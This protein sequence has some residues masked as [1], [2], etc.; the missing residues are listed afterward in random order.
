MK[1][2]LAWLLL[3][4]CLAVDAQ[5]FKW[6]DAQGK[7]HYG[8]QPPMDVKAQEMKITRIPPEAPSPDVEVAPVAIDHYPVRGLSVDAIG[9]AMQRAAPKGEDGDPVWAQASWSL[10]YRF[11]FDDSKGCRIDTLSVLVSTRL[12]MPE[13]LDREKAADELQ[14]KW[15]AFYR[16]L[17]AHEEGHRDNGIRAANDLARKIRKLGSARD[18]ATLD[19]DVRELGGRITREY[20][21]V[22]QDYDRSTGHGATQGATLR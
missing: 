14:G 16:A 1:F 10:D 6:T 17:L 4:L 11:G 13:W 19:R 8:D 15:A 3:P 12:R 9:A 22:D 5:V 7:V 21:L 20:E 18:C 2:P